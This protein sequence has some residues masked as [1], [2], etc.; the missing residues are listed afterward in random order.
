M[1]E[2]RSVMGLVWAPAHFDFFAMIYW[3]FLGLYETL[4]LWHLFGS[5]LVQY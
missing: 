3:T 4:W 1:N 5:V 2:S